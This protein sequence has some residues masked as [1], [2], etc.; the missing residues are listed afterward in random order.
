MG[1]YAIFLLDDDDP[2]TR[3]SARVFERGSEP[4]N[5]R[6]DD[7]KVRLAV[8]HKVCLTERIIIGRQACK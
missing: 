4:N 3:E 8:G 2:M 7:K 6:A 5:T 1:C